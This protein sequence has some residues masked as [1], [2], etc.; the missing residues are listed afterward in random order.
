MKKDTRRAAVVQQAEAE[1]IELFVGNTHGAEFV[2]MGRVVIV[3]ERAEDPV[4]TALEAL[5]ALQA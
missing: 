2:T 5:E 3:N 4:A 1:G